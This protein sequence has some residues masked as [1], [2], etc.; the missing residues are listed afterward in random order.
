MQRVPE[1]E[2]MD[3]PTQALAYA[4]ADFEQP[5]GQF[6]AQFRACFPTWPGTGRVVELGCGPGDICRRF[7]LA[8][9]H[10]QVIGVDG[11]RAMLDIGRQD[12]AA[13]GLA[14]RVQLLQAYLPADGLPHPHYDAIISNSL[15]HHLRDPATLWQSIVRYAAPGA[16]VWVMDLR[17]PPNRNA[18]AEL[19]EQYAAT[20][21]DILRA[22]FHHSLLAA[23]TV[24][25][26]RA[27]LRQAD[28]G[29]LTVQP[30]GDRHLVVQ[31]S[32]PR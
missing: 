10:C 7:A 6:I 20:E 1:P 2:L 30:L 11:A 15:L 24:E 16:P 29:W 4:R 9:P 32:C 18:A 21:A 28:L 13:A 27:Q 12:L 8:Y 5:H 17:R 26:V 22:D 14:D 23:Y 31:G 25:E 19:V 3:D